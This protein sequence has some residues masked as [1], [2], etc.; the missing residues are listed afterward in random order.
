MDSSHRI[1]RHSKAAKVIEA[2]G[3]LLGILETETEVL[4]YR[5]I[6]SCFDDSTADVTLSVGAIIEGNRCS[7]EDMYEFYLKMV[8]LE[9]LND[10]ESLNDPDISRLL[11]C[12][13]AYLVILLNHLHRIQ[14]R[15]DP[16]LL[17]F[18]ESLQSFHALDV[19]S[20]LFIAN[21]FHVLVLATSSSRNHDYL[22]KDLK[23][24]LAMHYAVHPQYH[25]IDV[26][27][28]TNI[29]TT[30]EETMA[31]SQSK[32]LVIG[33]SFNTS[34]T[35]HLQEVID[36]AAWVSTH[37]VVLVKQTTPLVPF[38]Q[39]ATPRKFLLCIKSIE[40]LEYSFQ[41][42]LELIRP[43]DFVAFLHIADTSPCKAV[44]RSQGYLKI[45]EFTSGNDKN[46]LFLKEQMQVLI[47][48]ARL[49][50][51]ILFPGQSH[52]LTVGEQIIQV[53]RDEGVDIIV[54]NRGNSN[55]IPREC[56]K[57]ASASA[58]VLI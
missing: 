46:L 43:I 30:I 8:E 10:D 25:H 16:N 19:A 28:S 57:R 40:Y 38:S 58:V 2:A 55:R 52:C 20:H 48:E 22:A 42:I 14:L 17:V 45:N 3:A 4:L 56:V 1:S 35:D 33:Q 53:A 23:T 36:W 39:T 44:S 31:I 24:R 15:R 26:I 37:R 54:L 34:K 51:D 32:Y 7:N 12:L 11:D 6:L 50:S 29:I 41:R 27:S 9:R 21:P 13:R 5:H 49:Y 47:S 18:D